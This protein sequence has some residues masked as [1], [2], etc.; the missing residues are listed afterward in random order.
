LIRARRRAP[1]R[2]EGKEDVDYGYVGDIESV[3]ADVLQKQL[4]AD[5]MP[6]V[7]PISC[8]ETGTILNI[9]ADTVADSLLL[10]VFTNEGTGTLVVDDIGALTLAEQASAGEQK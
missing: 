3:D 1:V 10:E 7:S 4:D 2:E 9:N 5:L 6:I 8:D